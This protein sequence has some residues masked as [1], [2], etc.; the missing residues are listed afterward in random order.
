MA[1]ENLNAAIDA[2]VAAVNAE[3]KMRTLDYKAMVGE[4]LNADEPSLK[5]LADKLQALH[6]D[7][8]A[9]DAKVKSIAE[10]GY[11]TLAIFLRVAKLFLPH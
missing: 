4:F 11:P 3:E 5:A 7:D 10:A 1:M 6:L 9:L 8:A 2:V